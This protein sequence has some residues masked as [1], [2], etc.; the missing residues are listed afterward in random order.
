MEKG[1]RSGSARCA[2]FSQ[3]CY[4]WGFA[5][6][7]C[8]IFAFFLQNFE[9]FLHIFCVHICQAQGYASAILVYFFHLLD[10]DE[11]EPSVL[12]KFSYV[13]VFVFVSNADFH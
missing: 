3:V 10:S 5:H 13:F 12:T 7:F 2:N 11:L 4:F 1:S 6:V 8:Q 9:H